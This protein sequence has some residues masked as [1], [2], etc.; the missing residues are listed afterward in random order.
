MYKY[1]YRHKHSYTNSGLLYIVE[2]S[3]YIS[4]NVSKYTTVF[5]NDYKTLTGL[6]ACLTG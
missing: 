2:K 6:H 1:V 5:Q 4:I 3:H